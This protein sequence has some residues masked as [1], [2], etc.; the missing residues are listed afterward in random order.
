MGVQCWLRKT[1]CYPWAR[2]TKSSV[3]SNQWILLIAFLWIRV[4]NAKENTNTSTTT[5]AQGVDRP[6]GDTSLE[7]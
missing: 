7:R 5:L 4:F 3:P 2:Y 1:F 6:F